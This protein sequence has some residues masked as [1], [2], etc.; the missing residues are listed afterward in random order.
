MRVMLM[1]YVNN[2]KQYKEAIYFIVLGILIISQVVH[3]VWIS[4]EFDKVSQL[5]ISLDR[6]N[7]QVLC[8][9]IQY[10]ERVSEHKQIEVLPCNYLSEEHK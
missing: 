10:L 5:E 2:I 8:E 3:Q 9:R 6:K 4:A 7:H 1:K